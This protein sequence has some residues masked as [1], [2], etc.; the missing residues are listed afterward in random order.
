MNFTSYDDSQRNP[1]LVESSP[2]ERSHSVADD[3]GNDQES[4]EDDSPSSSELSHFE[5][6][7]RW[8]KR[9]KNTLL[10]LPPELQPSNCLTLLRDLLGVFLDDPEK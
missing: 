2:E 1:K 9:M 3:E 6:S 8:A 10:G 4:F 5:M 7:Q